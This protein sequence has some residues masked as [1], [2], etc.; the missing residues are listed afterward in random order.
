MTGMTGLVALLAALALTGA[1]AWW[2]RARDGRITAARPAPAA[3][4]D[5]GPAGGL[6][7]PVRAALAGAPAVTLVQVS[8]TFCAPCR[9]AHAVLSALAD[10]TDG[11][12]HVEIDVTAQPEVAAA[13]GVLRTPTTL[14]YS[15]DG[16][17]LLRVGGVPKTA[18]LVDALRPHLP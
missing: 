13:L 11:V 2:L 1:A 5:S 12:R 8:T 4:A 7:E 17:E 18:A 3:P 16:T 14:A 9:H 10:G 15:G 6:P